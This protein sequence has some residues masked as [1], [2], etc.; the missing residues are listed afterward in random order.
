MQTNQF[1]A[2]LSRGIELPDGLHDG[3]DESDAEISHRDR[4]HP[5]E[6]A[7]PNARPWNGLS[8]RASELDQIQSLLLA[9][10]L[11]LGIKDKGLGNGEMEE[12]IEVWEELQQKLPLQVVMLSG[13]REAADGGVECRRGGRRR[14]GLNRRRLPSSVGGEARVI[15]SR[16]RPC[17]STSKHKKND[18]SYMME[19]EEHKLTIAFRA[20]SEI[21]SKEV[22]NARHH[23]VPPEEARSLVAMIGLPIGELAIEIAVEKY[24]RRLNVGVDD[25]RGAG[26]VKVGD[27]GGELERDGGALI[28]R[29]WRSVGGVMELVVQGAVGD[30]LHYQGALIFRVAEELHDVWVADVEQDL[31]L[32][33]E[34][35][36][37]ALA[38]AAA[39]KLPE[40]EK[41][42]SDVA[43][44]TDRKEK[45]KTQETAE[46][47]PET[48]I[49]HD[50]NNKIKV[51]KVES[52]TQGLKIRGA[53][54]RILYEKLVKISGL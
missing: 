3:N 52:E 29:E 19:E 38:A 9:K 31:E 33:V 28:P 41:I 35:G 11:R 8:N 43:G 26:I 25:V 18:T 27:G 50:I 32:L 21:R 51:A 39:A 40:A 54:Y 37:H 20:Y 46:Q 15:P 10:G 17:T 24:V 45:N 2:F 14:A 42:G 53:L 5:R 13:D 49:N 23:Q 44:D 4:Q 48:P 7:L 6:R 36:V 12:S 1:A 30:E 16:I 34:G 47:T 22:A